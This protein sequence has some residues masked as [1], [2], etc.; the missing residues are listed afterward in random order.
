VSCAIDGVGNELNRPFWER[1][2]WPVRTAAVVA[3][4]TFRRRHFCQRCLSDQQTWRDASGGATLQSRSMLTAPIGPAW[5][6]HLL[7]RR[8][9]LLDEGVPLISNLMGDTAGCG[10][11]RTP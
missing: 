7:I 10:S 1:R 3:I 8:A 11:R 2:R 4:F 6:Q 9:M 5:H